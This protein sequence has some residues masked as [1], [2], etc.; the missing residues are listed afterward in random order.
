MNV[1][2]EWIRIPTDNDLP[3]FLKACAENKV[4]N[5]DD[6]NIESSTIELGFR[7]ALNRNSHDVSQYLLSV[8]PYLRDECHHELL[9]YH[10]RNC[11]IDMV[12]HIL[13]EYDINPSKYMTCLFWKTKY[14]DENILY[15]IFEY[16]KQY[17]SH[18]V[19]TFIEQVKYYFSPYETII[20]SVT[21]L[22]LLVIINNR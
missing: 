4:Q 20:K 9:L 3:P 17:N 18:Y 6:Q 21:N 10:L 1:Q 2:C 12:L 7:L 8:Y 13:K 15:N 22:S 16:V 5:I 14:H 19:V 11:N